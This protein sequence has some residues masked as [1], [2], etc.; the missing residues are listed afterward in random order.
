MPDLQTASRISY[1]TLQ[2]LTG[3]LGR[4]GEKEAMRTSISGVTIAGPT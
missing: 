3:D 1:T 2:S 4:H